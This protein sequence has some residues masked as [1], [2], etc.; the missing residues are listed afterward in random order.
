M[1]LKHSTRSIRLKIEQRIRRDVRGVR[2]NIDATVCLL[3][4]WLDTD[5][6]GESQY[7]FEYWF[8]CL[9]RFRI[10]FRLLTNIQPDDYI[11]HVRNETKVS[12]TRVC[13]L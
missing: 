8:E 3:I 1:L 9:A 4:L 5:P 13:Q 2:L 11:R 12:A 7:P 6:A 10:A